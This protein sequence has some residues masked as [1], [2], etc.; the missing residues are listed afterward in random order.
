MGCLTPEPPHLLLELQDKTPR[1]IGWEH[2]KTDM[3][4]PVPP[5]KTWS[6]KERAEY[7]AGFTRARIRGCPLHP[8]REVQAA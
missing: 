6:R 1:E 4:S 5:V 7:F 3:E 8:A 2:G